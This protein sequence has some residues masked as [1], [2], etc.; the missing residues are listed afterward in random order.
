MNVLK[1]I[2][3]LFHAS[4]QPVS[5]T[6]Q[7]DEEASVDFLLKDSIPY[8]AVLFIDNLVKSGSLYIREEAS[9]VYISTKL[10]YLYSDKERWNI[11]LHNISLWFTFMKS[12]EYWNRKYVDAEN[13]AI[14]NSG[15]NPEEMSEEE[16]NELKWNARQKVSFSGC[17][18]ENVGKY[19][20]AMVAEDDGSVVL[21]GSYDNGR[22]SVR[23]YEEVQNE[24]NI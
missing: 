24:L 13:E 21:V 3:N 4:P 7:S 11:F 10:V 17:S 5:P 1:I 6:P 14:R 9:E 18:M 8:K 16:L 19:N 22:L 12:R 20:F 15:K 23:D 2:K